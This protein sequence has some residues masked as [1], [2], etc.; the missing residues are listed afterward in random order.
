[1]QVFVC[2]VGKR[3]IKSY[4]HKDRLNVQKKIRTPKRYDSTFLQSMSCSSQ[5]TGWWKAAFP[6]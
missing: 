1:M 2:K 6:L 5:P 4:L 3:S